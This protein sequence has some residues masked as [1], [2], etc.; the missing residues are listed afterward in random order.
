[1]SFEVPFVMRI[2]EL[3]DMKL[4]D[5]C[6]RMRTGHFR[7]IFSSSDFGILEYIEA[8]AI[9]YRCIITYVRDTSISSPDKR[10]NGETQQL[11]VKLAS[12]SA[13]YNECNP[14]EC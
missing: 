9:R 8:L 6:I 1:M 7:F 11:M 3:F 14:C 13:T 2:F 5:S 12:D 10:T 4:H